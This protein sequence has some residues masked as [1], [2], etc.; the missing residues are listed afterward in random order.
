MI[1]TVFKMMEGQEM[2]S[3]ENKTKYIYDNLFLML[4]DSTQLSLNKYNTFLYFS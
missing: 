4:C 1:N 3:G 2:K